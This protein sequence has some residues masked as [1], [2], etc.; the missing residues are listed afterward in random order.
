MG[1]E[2]ERV[3]RRESVEKR[4][5]VSERV[6]RG[7]LMRMERK[8]KREEESKSATCSRRGEVLAGAT[9]IPNEHK[10]GRGSN[11]GEEESVRAI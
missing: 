1:V 7:R 4:E 8:E 2:S 5:C 6:R 10:A 3:L 11:E 9:L